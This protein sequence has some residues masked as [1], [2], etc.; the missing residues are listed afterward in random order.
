LSLQAAAL[1]AAAS[2]AVDGPGQFSAQQR[3]ASFRQQGRRCPSPDVFIRSM[4]A[5]SGVSAAQVVVC[6]R[7]CACGSIVVHEAF[8]CRLTSRAKSKLFRQFQSSVAVYT[9]KKFSAAFSSTSS[10]VSA[11][12]VLAEPLDSRLAALLGSICRLLEDEGQWAGDICQDA[13]H[14]ITKLRRSILQDVPSEFPLL[15]HLRSLCELDAC[16]G[17]VPDRLQGKLL[18]LCKVLGSLRDYLSAGMA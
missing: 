12:V 15:L 9:T 4:E 5:F 10:L 7:L 13:L 1:R 6:A 3:V 17:D 2:A 14:L 11:H 8:L 18:S 16:V